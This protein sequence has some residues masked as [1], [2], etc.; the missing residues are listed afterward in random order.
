[1]SKKLSKACPLVFLVSILLFVAGISAYGIDNHY[2]I[3]DEELIKGDYFKGADRIINDG[4]IGGDFI[5]GAQEVEHFGVIEGDFIAAISQGLIGGKVKGDVR[6]LGQNIIIQGEVY[7][8][9]SVLA[10]NFIIEEGGAIDGSLHAFVNYL[11]VKGTIGGDI[12]GS[13]GTAII[14][15]NIKG[16]VTLRAEKIYLEPNAVIEGNLIYSSPK[17]QQIDSSKVK[18]TIEYRPSEAKGFQ[19]A[20]RKF[21]AGYRRILLFVRSVFLAAYLLIGLLFLRLFQKPAERAVDYIKEKP[22]ITLAI[23]FCI[24]GGVPVVAI[25]LFITIVGIPISIL[26]STLYFIL[27]HLAKIPVELW[28]GRKIL[29]AADRPYLSFII[30]TLLI[31][32]LRFIPYFGWLATIGIVAL[33]IGAEAMMIKSYYQK[34]KTL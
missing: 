33:G 5:V 2:Y 21:R 32:A 22:L 11:N 12:K 8:N 4:T 6:S 29:R 20:K 1:M 7:K 18:G 30:G 26:S 17:V 24:V 27:I 10:S 23:G 28:L 9:T 34:Q 16:D 19:V 15:G 14:T 13:V 3:G 25:L 31:A